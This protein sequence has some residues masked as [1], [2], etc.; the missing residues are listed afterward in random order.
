M[1]D[2]VRLMASS[3]LHH[4]AKSGYKS[5]GDSNLLCKV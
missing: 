1:S 4:P 3:N 5:D 2:L